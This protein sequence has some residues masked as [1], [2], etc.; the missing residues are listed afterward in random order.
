MIAHDDPAPQAR[1]FS[2][3]RRVVSVADNLLLAAVLAGGGAWAY[4]QVTDRSADAPRPSQ[5]TLPPA[6]SS[7]AFEPVEMLAT[8]TVDSTVHDEPYERRHFG[9]RWADV[10]RN[11]CDTRNDIL[12]RDLTGVV[13]DPKTRG[14]V[15]LRGTLADPYSGRTIDFVKG[16]TT[17]TAVQIDHIVPLAD[18]WRKGAHRWSPETRLTFANDP[19]NLAAVSEAANRAKGDKD[20]SRYLPDDDGFLCTYVGRQVVVK[21]TYRLSVTTDERD[22]MRTVLANCG[23]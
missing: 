12:T 7:E 5:R 3:V 16:D 9:Q 1:R 21:A 15:V 19:R 2:R 8:L 18:A 10:D 13:H 14:C 17:S 11:G 4:Q 20:A 23:G 6:S 22:A